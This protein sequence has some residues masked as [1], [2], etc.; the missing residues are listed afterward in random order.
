MDS[1][2]LGLTIGWLGGMLIMWLRLRAKYSKDFY[3][4]EYAIRNAQKS[5]FNDFPD[6]ARAYLGCALPENSE[7]HRVMYY[8][9]KH[10]ED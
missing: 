7:S 5:L 3:I 4:M 1:L 2:F 9:L 10:K 8:P 6:E